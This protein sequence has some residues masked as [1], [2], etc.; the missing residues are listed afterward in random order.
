MKLIDA[1]KVRQA[2][3]AQKA[4]WSPSSDPAVLARL[5]NVTVE[6]LRARLGVNRAE[7]LQRQTHTPVTPDLAG[8]VADFNARKDSS[9]WVFAPSIQGAIAPSPERIQ[10]INLPHGFSIGNRS[11]QPKPKPKAMPRGRKAPN[12][13]T[14]DWRSHNGIDCVTPIEDQGQCGSCVAFATVAML[15]SMLLVEHDLTTDLSEADIFFCGGGDCNNGWQPFFAVS[16]AVS[17]GVPPA[18]CFPYSAT[19]SGGTNISCSP[20]SQRNAQAA[21]PVK[22]TSIFDINQR[23]TYLANVGPMIACF[24]VHEDFFIYFFLRS[25]PLQVYTHV[26]TGDVFTAV[27]GQNAAKGATSLVM[28]SI[29][30]NSGNGQI[31]KIGN[32]PVDLLLPNMGIGYIQNDNTLHLSSPLK[33]SVAAGSTITAE[34]AIGGHCVEIIGYDD[35]RSCWICKNSWGTDD[36]GAGFFRIGYG[37]C[38]IDTDISILGLINFGSPFWGVWDTQITTGFG[39]ISSD[40]LWTG[41]FAGA[42]E[43]EVL[44]YFHG[45]G[46]WWLGSYV[47]GQIGWNLVSQTRNP[48]GTNFGD[49]SKFPTWIGDFTG[50]GHSQVLFYSP[51]DDNLW[52]G[53]YS[54][55]QINWSLAGNTRGFRHGINEGRPFWTGNF[56]GIGRSQIC[57][58]S[59]VTVIG[60]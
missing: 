15:E 49:T 23:K 28:Q 12:P 22:S 42:H 38:G 53:S 27:V 58:I 50:S 4:P 10:S 48:K 37:Q 14:V 13:S 26:S 3:L 60:G 35:S 21:R 20:C 47:N 39:N 29:P 2:C 6:S 41:N 30:I 36:P 44:F 5:K 57:F 24:D 33:T 45:D 18:S 17:K 19:A 43:T 11:P 40:P 52:L 51:G 46:H 32:Q 56:S 9:P 1:E 31:I 7:Q 54:G 59:P 25:D 8:I 16:Y 34:P 55:N